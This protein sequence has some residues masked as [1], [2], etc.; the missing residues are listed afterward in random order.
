MRNCLRSYHQ[1]SLKNEI[2]DAS[3]H[4][5]IQMM[6]T[7]VLER[8]F[9]CRVAIKKQDIETKGLA[10]NKA[11]GI[12]SGLNNSLDM[13]QGGEISKN[14]SKLYQFSLLKLSDA[15][16]HNDITAIDDVIEVLKTIKEGW[17]GIPASQHH[18]TQPAEI[19]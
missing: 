7:G 4:R 9:E 16:L 12:I 11:I 14:L 13:E 2:E 3:P 15:N 8:L 6:F 17:D 10:I 19:S 5:V 1:V 18:M